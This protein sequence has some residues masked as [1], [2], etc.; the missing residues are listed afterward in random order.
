MVINAQA[1][2]VFYQIRRPMENLVLQIQNASLITVIMDTAVHQAL[3][4]HRIRIAPA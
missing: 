2:D 4:V 3:A 1:T